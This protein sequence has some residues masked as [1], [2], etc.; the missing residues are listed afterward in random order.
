MI[1][2]F[3]AFQWRDPHYSPVQQ[4]EF[5]NMPV[6]NFHTE[7][8]TPDGD[9]STATLTPRSQ[10][11]L[12]INIV[13]LFSGLEIN[14]V[15][16]SKVQLFVQKSH[17]TIEM[18]SLYKKTAERFNEPNP[19]DG[20]EIEKM[21]NELFSNVMREESFKHIDDPYHPAYTV[22]H[23]H[24]VFTHFKN[25]PEKAVETIGEETKGKSGAYFLK[26]SRGEKAWVFKPANQEPGAAESHEAASCK[27]IRPGEGARREHIADI[28]NQSSN[29]FFAIPKTVLIYFDGKIGSAQAFIPNCSSVAKYSI[30]VEK[31]C[32]VTDRIDR[33]SLHRSILFDIFFCNG[34]RHLG[35]LLLKEN[36]NG[37]LKAIMIDHGLILS[38]DVTD[39]MKM[40]QIVY[41]QN[42]APLSDEVRNFVMSAPIETWKKVLRTHGIEEKAINMIDR[43]IHF[44]QECIRASDHCQIEK[45]G[46][47]LEL[48]DIAL[49]AM[50]LHQEIVNAN[51]ETLKEYADFITEFRNEVNAWISGERG[52]EKSKEH[53]MFKR[54][55]AL[56]LNRPL[57][58]LKMLGLSTIPSMGAEAFARSLTSNLIG[59]VK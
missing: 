9:K 36:L 38:T 55:R 24:E 43:K 7:L 42:Q 23:L 51:D 54:C 33:E 20:E 11:E 22:Y 14:S 1:N 26:T 41:Q 49:M 53:A 12:K 30:G 5:E 45:G 15:D 46:A 56:L 58:G 10:S 39:P 6:R 47:A 21:Y 29:H 32:T 35:N 17:D 25:S 8:S 27:G 59:S 19:V 13:S 48:K 31:D 44:V 3:Q 57:Q 2:N 50:E 4:E 37:E 52:G 28:I 40:D 34:D 18:S 16:N